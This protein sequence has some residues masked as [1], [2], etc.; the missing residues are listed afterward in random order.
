MCERFT[1]DR[2]TS[3]MLMDKCAV[4]ARTVYCRHSSPSWLVSLLLT[5]ICVYLTLV[6]FSTFLNMAS[7]DSGCP[8]IFC[9]S[10]V[11]QQLCTVVVV[12]WSRT[13]TIRTTS[14]IHQHN[15]PTDS[16]LSSTTCSMLYK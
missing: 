4:S 12:C 2:T 1:V 3:L 14:S 13:Y 15:T 6:Y 9:A 10:V 8:K 16:L 7:V 11:R 5:S